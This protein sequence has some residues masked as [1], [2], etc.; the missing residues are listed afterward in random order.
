MKSSLENDPRDT[1]KRIKDL[2][3]LLG[4]PESVGEVGVDT[5]VTI[6]VSETEPV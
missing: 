6:L 2:P 1:E 4:D 3:T 5:P